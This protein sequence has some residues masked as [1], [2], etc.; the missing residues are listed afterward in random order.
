MIQQIEFEL[1]IEDSV[2]S[3]MLYKKYAEQT[4]RVP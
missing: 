1:N 3:L 2:F 4:S